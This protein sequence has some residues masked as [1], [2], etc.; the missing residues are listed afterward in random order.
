QD[1]SNGGPAFLAKARS[2]AMNRRHV[3]SARATGYRTSTRVALPSRSS[4]FA[5]LTK[6]ED[7]A[8]LA[9]QN[10]ADLIERFETHALHLTRFQKRHVLLGDTNALGEVLRTHLAFRQHH[11]EVDDDGHAASHDLA[12][13]VGDLN[14]GPEDVRERHD[15]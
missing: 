14:A 3:S 5:L 1:G 11:V 6:L 4:V 12:I 9:L 10:I 2:A 13:V 8:G 7:V 15:E